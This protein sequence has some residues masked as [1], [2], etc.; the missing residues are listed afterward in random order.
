MDIEREIADAQVS[1][2]ALDS[3]ADYHLAQIVHR[4]W[5]VGGANGWNGPDSSGECS[6]PKHDCA[7]SGGDSE[8]FFDDRRM[9]ANIADSLANLG[10]S[11]HRSAHQIKTEAVDGLQKI[12]QSAGRQGAAFSGSNYPDSHQDFAQRGA[13]CRLEQPA[14]QKK[15]GGVQCHDDYQRGDGELQLGSVES[16]ESHEDPCVHDGEEAE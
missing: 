5:V 1:R 4:D 11:R 16:A 6:D 15:H 9:R 12:A 13:T 2:V 3:D 8:T 10:T 7:D 14:V